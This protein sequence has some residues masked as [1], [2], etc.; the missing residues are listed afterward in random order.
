MENMSLRSEV[1][2]LSQNNCKNPRCKV[3]ELQKA[4]TNLERSVISERKSHHKLV[5]KLRTDK[6]DLTRQLG[7]ARDSE[8]SLKLRLSQMTQTSVPV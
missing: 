2:E 3:Q 4:I 8:R 5:E 6:I 7:E 1:A